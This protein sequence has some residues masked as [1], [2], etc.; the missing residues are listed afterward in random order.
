MGLDLR[1]KAPQRHL[2][3]L[4]FTMRDMCPKSSAY[5]ASKDAGEVY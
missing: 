4:L 5:D 3:L 1:K 2:R